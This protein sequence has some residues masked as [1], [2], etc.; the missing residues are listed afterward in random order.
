MADLIHGNT[1]TGATKQDLIAALVQKELAFNAQLLPL[2]TNVSQF[3]IKGAK[4]ISF[5]KL[6]SFSVSNRT[7]GA[8]GDASVLTSSVDKLDLDQA[9]YLAWIVDSNDEVQSTIE[10]QSELA[11]RA[12]A[13]HG[14]YVD[15]HVISKLEAHG[16]AI[17]TA[18]DITRDIVLDMREHLLANFANKD[19][20]SLIVGVDQEK[21]ML[22]IEE[23]TRAEVYGSA[24]IP[25]GMIGKVYGV[26][27]Y[28][29][30]GLAASSYYMFDKAGI[31]LAFQKTPAMSE[32]SANEFGTGA[33][34]VAM[35]QLFGAKG[36]Q[37]VSGVSKLI[38]KDDN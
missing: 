28:V 6:T 25:N 30:N 2:I 23:F 17:A 27:V 16:Y 8:Q 10:W 24:V 9:A 26:P 32:Q 11:M 21:A 7:S 22:K 13:A 1:Q 4:S 33:K 37:L 12:A 36:L 29:H 31:A 14:R 34:R 5:P 3:A 38:V 35:D 18:G 19:A 20:L 15:T